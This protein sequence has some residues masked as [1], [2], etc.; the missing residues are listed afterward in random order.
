M[1][2]TDILD[3]DVKKHAAAI[4]TDAKL[5][6]LQ[7]KMANVLLLNA[8][9]RLL[10]QE[11]HRIRVKELA[12]VVGFD[13]NDRKCLRDALIG[14]MKT[15]FKWNVI[16]KKGVEHDWDACVMI[17]RASMQGAWCTYSYSP[18][19]REKLYQPQIYAQINMSIQRNFTSGYALALYENCLSYRG[20]GETPWWTI[21][22]I[23][24]VLGLGDSAFY[25]EYRDL[26]RKVLKPAIAQA[27]EF[28]DIHL[29]LAPPKRKGRRI[30]ALKF[31]IG[32]NPQIPLFRPGAP[33][34]PVESMGCL[35]QKD[36]NTTENL[37]E[38]LHSFGLTSKQSDDVLAEHDET[39]IAENLA[40]VADHLEAGKVEAQNLARYTYSALRDDYR[41]KVPPAVNDHMA[42]EEAVKE[43]VQQNKARK[44]RLEQLENEFSA[45]RLTTALATLTDRE[46]KRLERDCIDAMKEGRDVSAST[47]RKQYLERGFSGKAAQ[48]YFRTYAR[49][50]LLTEPT[51]QEFDAFVQTQGEDLTALRGSAA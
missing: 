27:N 39:Y 20:A 34:C 37:Q 9:P 38:R 31:R 47:A 19:L 18:D 13:S 48:I 46:R 32:D 43:Q 12:E 5:S 28:S 40:I 7:R 10:S 44:E 11:S 30:V 50:Q 4:H 25:R 2:L 42:R 33:A 23:R 6:L 51:E 41:P 1:A 3:R 16:K 14:L 17:Y 49:K 35:F 29:E 21:Q 15:V 45:H 36:V 26:N 24:Q 8:Y 22:E